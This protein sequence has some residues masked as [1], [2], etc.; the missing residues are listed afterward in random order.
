MPRIPTYTAQGTGIGVPGV[1]RAQP[2]PN[3]LGYVANQVSR[4][5]DQVTDVYGKLQAQS[6]DIAI[7]E[8]KSKWDNGVKQIALDLEEDSDVIV[9]PTKYPVKFQEKLSKLET[10]LVKSAPNKN[11]GN[12]FSL[13]LGRKSPAVVIAAKEHGLKMFRL[14]EIARMD[15]LE[16]TMSDEAASAPSAEAHKEKIEDYQAIITGAE[17]KGIFNPVVAEK[18]RKDFLEKTG[19]K[20]MEVVGLRNP[21]LM[22]EM[23]EA[24]AFDHVDEDKRLALIDTITARQASKVAAARVAHTAALARH[25]E[26]V[27]QAMSEHIANQTLTKD[28]IEEWRGTV[29]DNKARMWDKALDD[30]IR[31]IGTGNPAIEKDM[32]IDVYET[33]LNPRET[34]DRLTVLAQKGLIGRDKYSGWMTILN[35]RIKAAIDEKMGEKKEGEVRVREIKKSRYEAAVSNIAGTFRTTGG[36]SF[37]FDGIANEAASQMREEIQRKAETLGG[38]RD[39]LDLYFELLPKY[40][41]MVDDRVAPRIQVLR[42]K[43]DYKTPAELNAARVKLGEEA[44]YNQVQIMSE[45]RAIMSQRA[46]ILGKRP[47]V[48]TEPRQ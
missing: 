33:R 5:V 28:L 12:G 26:T 43:L 1:D 14:Q 37:D 19:V 20:W 13:Y 23:A 8:M 7:V 40:I 24:G 2:G 41:A 18:R 10:E 44:Y 17:A 27:E 3:V 30:Q 45:L 35:G 4:A 16:E 31:G 39:A 9:D 38:N 21:E 42:E 6:D 47:K 34:A 15:R 36:L 11:V 22:L 46:R 48:N 32:E 29:D 25:R